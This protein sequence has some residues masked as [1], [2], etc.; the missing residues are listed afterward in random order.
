MS[1]VPVCLYGDGADGPI[2]RDIDC[3]ASQPVVTTP[4][5]QEY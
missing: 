4:R 1:E 5:H 3:Q 2:A